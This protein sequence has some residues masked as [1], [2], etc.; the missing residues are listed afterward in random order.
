MILSLL[1]DVTLNGLFVSES[2]K[3]EERFLHVS[4]KLKQSDLVFANLESP[5]RGSEQGNKN[6]THAQSIKHRM[7]G[8]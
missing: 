7:P 6:K 4:Q 3:N 5:I 2:E 8:E 1:G